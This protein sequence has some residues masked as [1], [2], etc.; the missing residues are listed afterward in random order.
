MVKK[1]GFLNFLLISLF[2]QY[3]FILLRESLP[4]AA[5]SDQKH[6]GSTEL[7]TLRVSKATQTEFST[8][9]FCKE[10]LNGR[11]TGILSIIAAVKHSRQ[12]LDATT[13][14]KM[15]PFAGTCL[16]IRCCCVIPVKLLLVVE[17]LL[18]RASFFMRTD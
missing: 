8:L 2:E 10:T 7:D 17:L 4:V 11:S 15:P 13:E 18:I 9:C 16:P 1:L 12:P 6:H 5:L 14:T 3:E